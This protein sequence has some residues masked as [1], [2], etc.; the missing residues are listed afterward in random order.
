MKEALY[1]EPGAEGSVSCSLCPLGCSISPSRH[2]QCG[3]R[4]NRNTRLVSMTWGR[5]STEEVIPVEAVPLYHFHPGSRVLLVGSMGCTMRC[6]FCSTWRVSLMGTRT[7]FL[8]PEDLVLLAREKEVQ[9]VVFGVNEPLLFFEFIMDA[10]PLLREAGFFVAINTN[11]F[12]NTAPLFD[13]LSVSDAFLVDFKGFTEEF[14]QSVTGGYLREIQRA[15]FSMNVKTHLELSAL[16]IGDVN[17]KD[18]SIDEFL[19]WVAHLQP[20]PPP[21]HLLQ[22]RPSYQYTKPPTDTMRMY[23]LHEKARRMLP[24]VYLSNMEGREANTTY[25]PSCKKPLIIRTVGDRR[26]FNLDGDQCVK[27]GTK[28]SLVK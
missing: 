4:V 16:V 14:Y 5:V 9:G 13:L 17:D 24:Y 8:A 18:E 27:C 25:C 15:V 23:Y 3:V 11:G 2:G 12:M 10:A 19:R 1:S 28:I 22:Y 21:L 6:P 26:S 20:A 7:R